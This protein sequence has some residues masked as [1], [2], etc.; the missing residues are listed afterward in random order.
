MDSGETVCH[1]P[2]SFGCGN[3]WRQTAITVLS[4]LV[5]TPEW[6]PMPSLVHVE[7]FPYNLL[8]LPRRP[9]LNYKLV[10]RLGRE[11]CSMHLTL[12]SFLN[13]RA[14]ARASSTFLT[15]LFPI[16][17]RLHRLIQF[18]ASVDRDLEV[19]LLMSDVAV[20]RLK[21]R[22]ARGSVGAWLPCLSTSMMPIRD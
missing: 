12:D 6:S 10:V 5:L 20:V 3:V 2:V 1:Y 11:S 15:D 4:L 8:P 14:F 13:L 18:I 17:P 21:E 19:L 7:P 9:T 16:P 22:D